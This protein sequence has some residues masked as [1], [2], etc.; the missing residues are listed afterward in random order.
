MLQKLVSLKKL[1][2]VILNKFATKQYIFHFIYP[3]NRVC[4]SCE[5]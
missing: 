1:T 5:M 4:P 2:P 3:V